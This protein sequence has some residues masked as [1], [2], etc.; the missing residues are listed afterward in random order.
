MILTEKIKTITT[1]IEPTND[2]DGINKAFPDEKLFK[3]A[4]LIIIRQ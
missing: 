4:S 2:L 1:N 3:K